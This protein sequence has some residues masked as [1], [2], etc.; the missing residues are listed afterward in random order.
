MKN[1]KTLASSVVLVSLFCASCAPFDVISGVS[2]VYGY[3][4]ITE[5]EDRVA[6]IE[7]GYSPGTI[8]SPMQNT[9][10]PNY[11]LLCTLCGYWKSQEEERLQHGLRYAERT[12]NTR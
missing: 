10:D 6:T 4:R 1:S 2:A 7:K 5:L 9:N 11:A 3:W 8:K 12:N